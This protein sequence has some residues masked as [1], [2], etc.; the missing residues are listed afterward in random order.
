[1]AC[2][3]HSTCSI[4][5]YWTI[6]ESDALS[7]FSASLAN[8]TFWARPNQAKPRGVSKATR[9]QAAVPREILNRVMQQPEREKK[10]RTP[11]EAFDKRDD[12]QPRAAIIQGSVALSAWHLYQLVGKGQRLNFDRLGLSRS[13]GPSASYQHQS[14]SMG[15]WNINRL[16]PSEIRG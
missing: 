4:S 6:Q 2:Q 13:S 3:H 9:H 14:R 5:R 12:L 7:L 15:V 8:R 11:V 10:K 1:M 16:V